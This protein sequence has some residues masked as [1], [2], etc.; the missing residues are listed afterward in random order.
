MSPSQP[1]RVPRRPPARIPER[2]VWVDGE[3]RRGRE[4]TLSVFDRGARDGEGLF[5]TVR[6]HRGQ[7]FLWERHL[8]RMVLSAAELGF[9]VPPPSTWPS[10]TV[11]VKATELR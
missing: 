3:L 7:P 1:A 10:T 5:E 11:S 2:V 8:E 6:V 9:P 4:A